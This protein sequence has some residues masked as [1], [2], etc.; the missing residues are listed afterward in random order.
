MNGKTKT[1]TTTIFALAAAFVVAALYFADP[2][3][4]N[5]RT[6]VNFG[7]PL[8][9]FGPQFGA[10]EAVREPAPARAPM[11]A[12]KSVRTVK[13]PP[14]PSRAIRKVSTA[15]QVASAELRSVAD[16][17]ETKRIRSTVSVLAIAALEK[18]L[19]ASVG[20]PQPQPREATKTARAEKELSCKKYVAAAGLTI[21][22][23]CDK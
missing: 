23:P 9:A 14:L 20:Q 11:A 7:P 15:P 4:A 8:G 21:T 5:G 13:H 12:P 22:V 3:T 1:M 16:G 18:P 10:R 6:N 2:A 17:A 19:A